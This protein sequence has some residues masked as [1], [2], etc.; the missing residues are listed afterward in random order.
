MRALQYLK[1]RRD[2]VQEFFLHLWGSFVSKEEIIL[3]I[4][5]KTSKRQS[6]KIIL[7]LSLSLARARAHTQKKFEN[8]LPTA[9][10]IW[11]IHKKKIIESSEGLIEFFEYCNANCKELIT[12]RNPMTALWFR[13]FLT[14]AIIK[15]KLYG[16]SIVI[17]CFHTL[18]RSCHFFFF[19]F[20]NPT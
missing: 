18:N 9:I 1:S 13:N 17:L 19:F 12:I 3:T 2:G 4:T 6:Y 8:Y 20:T 14:Y 5:S 10:I 7:S 15:L 16:K 11:I